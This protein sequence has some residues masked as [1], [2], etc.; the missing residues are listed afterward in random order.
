MQLLV[1][2]AA[3]TQLAIVLE[4]HAGDVVTAAQHHLQ[5]AAREIVVKPR[6]QQAA[7]DRERHGR[8]ER[9]LRAAI[10]FERGQ[11]GVADAALR[12]CAGEN[13]RG[14][15]EGETAGQRVQRHFADGSI[16][17]VAGDREERI[18]GVA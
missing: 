9:A 18:A 7:A 1:F 14:A 13:A 6:Q 11:L 8:G 5:I 2:A 17:A 15:V 10:G 16:A 12:G 4:D 3:E